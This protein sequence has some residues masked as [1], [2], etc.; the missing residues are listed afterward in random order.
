MKLIFFLLLSINLVGHASPIEKFNKR[1]VMVKNDA[2]QLQYIKARGVTNSFNLN[3]Y[4]QNL[5]EEIISLRDDLFATPVGMTNSK[6]A[7]FMIDQRINSFLDEVEIQDEYTFG[8]TKSYEESVKR[9]STLQ[10]ALKN[11]IKVN[12]KKAFAELDKKEIISNFIKEMKNY[13]QFLD[14]SVVAQ[15][16]R[17][18]FYY[19]KKIANKVFKTAINFAKKKLNNIPYIDL[20]TFIFFEAE[21]RVIEQRIISQNILLYY[22]SNHESELGLSAIEVDNVV[23]SIYESRIGFDGYMESKK[24]QKTWG[25]YGWKIFD[26]MARGAK[27]KAKKFEQLSNDFSNLDFIFYNGYTQKEEKVIYNLAVNAHQFSAKPSIAFYYDKPN[28]VRSLRAMVKLGQIGLGFLP[29][30]PSVIKRQIHNFANSWHV[31]QGLS[32]AFLY[33]YF[34]A[35]D[36]KDEKKAIK[37]QISNPYLKL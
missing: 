1:F 19:K 9:R 12:L 32:D 15:P 34:E 2:G 33:A 3:L 16:N 17:N 23:S 7:K 29:R 24:A 11:L 30:V 5:K 35:A 13:Y 37:A 25:D 14:V 20:A 18:Q 22:L 21:K 27:A 36:D 8:A 28:K 26:S 6:N 31:K 4:I 10:K